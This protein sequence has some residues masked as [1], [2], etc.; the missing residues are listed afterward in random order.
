M[1][2]DIERFVQFKVMSHPMVRCNSGPL[3]AVRILRGRSIVV[4]QGGGCS[5]PLKNAPSMVV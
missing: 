1:P 3:D 2:C 4:G 5:E